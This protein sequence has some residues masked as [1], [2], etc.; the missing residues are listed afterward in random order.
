MTALETIGV[1]IVGAGPASQ[2]IH[3]PTL[4]RMT[5][6]FRIAN[7][8]DVVPG[9]AE[10]VADRVGARASTSLEAL[11]DD[12][13]VDVVAV[14]SPKQ[15][16]A[17]QVVAA[18]EAGKRAVLCEKPLVVN[19]EEGG[20][21][22]A[23][24]ERTGVPVIVG[25]MHAYDPAWLAVSAGW[26]GFAD[27]V[28]TV[29]SRIVLPRNRRFEDW[30][31]EVRFRSQG[32]VFAMATPEAAAAV[33]RNLVLELTVHDL[34]LVRALLPAAAEL[35]VHS[36]RMLRP[37]G[38][39]IN[40]EVGDRSVQLIASFHGHS[41]PYWEL[42]AISDD[43]TLQVRFPPSYVHAGSAEATLRHADGSRS[44]FGPYRSNGYEGEYLALHAAATGA[45]A[46]RGLAAAVGDLDFT[47]AVAD[48]A[49]AALLRE[50]AA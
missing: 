19:A 22:A 44:V 27:R 48:Q 10:S 15:F 36:A 41:E 23:A 43:E 34:P 5:D 17:D 8:M 28:H 12:P 30:S 24:A 13:G 18:M 25:A 7:I 47:L 21:I 31:T 4:A 16:H 37:V 35:S 6:R 50:D 32:P 29:R 20:R 3:L 9:V 11:L 26:G 46:G 39:A 49:V 42:E 33:L 1:G 14:A 2:T 45:D 38:Y 40:G